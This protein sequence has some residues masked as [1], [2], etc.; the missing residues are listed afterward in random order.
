MDVFREFQKFLEW[1]DSW[2]NKIL[3][4]FIKPLWPRQITP[5]QITWFRIVLGLYLALLLFWFGNE[6]KQVML[7]VFFVGI[8]SDFIDGPI[9]RCLHK[10]TDFGAMLDPIADRILIMPIAVY[11][12][13]KFHKWL[14][15]CLIL[16][17][18][19]E[20][21]ASVL[22]KSK[23]ITIKSNIFGKTKM[24]IQSLVFVA[25]LFAWPN[26]PFQILL[27]VLWLSIPLCLLS[28]LH[29]VGEAYNPKIVNV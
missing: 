13:F 25:I 3:Y 9:A 28:I 26:P 21:I 23:S 27:D 29:K 6:D 20:G 8:L 12:L 4:F 10:T 1:L 14:L 15:L 19:A 16:I 11:S 5:N 17:E 7:A 24:V 2:R 18:I 22:V